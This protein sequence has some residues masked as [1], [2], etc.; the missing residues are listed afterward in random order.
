ME[1]R[2]AETALV[3]DNRPEASLL[4]LNGAGRPVGPAP[5]TRRSKVSPCG[6]EV[7]S[8]GSFMALD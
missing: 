8:A 4:R 5:I 6:D 1:E 7:S 2:V 3:H